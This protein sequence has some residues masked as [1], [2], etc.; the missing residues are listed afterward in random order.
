LCMFEEKVEQ[1]RTENRQIIA[2]TKAAEE[3]EGKSI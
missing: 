3:K 2:P 1:K